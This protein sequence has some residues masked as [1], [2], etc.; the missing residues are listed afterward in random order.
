VKNDGKKYWDSLS[1]NERIEL[2]ENYD[3]WDGFRFYKYEY[4]PNDLKKIINNEI[5]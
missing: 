1:E 2:L 5:K 4:L 3:Y